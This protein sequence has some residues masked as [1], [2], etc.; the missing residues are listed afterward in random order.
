MLVFGTRDVHV[1]VRPDR[2]DVGGVA[3]LNL[4]CAPDLLK[5][6]LEFFVAGCFLI[7]ERA[8]FSVVC[9]CAVNDGLQC[10]EEFFDCQLAYLRVVRARWRARM[11]WVLRSGTALNVTWRS[12]TSVAS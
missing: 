8:V 6:P 2:R 3:E 10:V 4:L 9:L 7:G 5:L 11:S 12:A 1:K